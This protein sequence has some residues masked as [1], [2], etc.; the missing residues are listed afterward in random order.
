MEL[1]GA[2]IRSRLIAV[3][4]IASA[5]SCAPTQPE[6]ARFSDELSELVVVLPS[7]EP[8]GPW[9]TGLREASPSGFVDEVRRR[10]P[11]GRICPIAVVAKIS[12]DGYHSV[13]APNGRLRLTYALLAEHS[14]QGAERFDLRLEAIEPGGQSNV[15]LDARDVPVRPGRVVIFGLQGRSGLFALGNG[16][17]QVD[18]PLNAAAAACD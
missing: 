10:F 7:T 3:V 6:H 18:A 5:L 15:L 1:E 16:T 17:R 8:E 9:T 13:A 14:K 4:A 12:P 11:A 2:G